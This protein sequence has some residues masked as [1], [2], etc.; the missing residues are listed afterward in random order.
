MTR[1]L[2]PGVGEATQTGSLLGAQAVGI[3][4]LSSFSVARHPAAF[5]LQV[6]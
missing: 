6:R 5:Q 2:L 1:K 4:C 3:T